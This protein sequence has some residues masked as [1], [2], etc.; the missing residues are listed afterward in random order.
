MQAEKAE[1][2]F[3]TK[4]VTECLIFPQIEL[5]PYPYQRLMAFEIKDAL[6]RL[7]EGVSVE[8]FE[9]QSCGCQF[10]RHYRIPCAHMFHYELVL[11]SSHRKICLD[12][13]F[14]NYGF[15]SDYSMD[16]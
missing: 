10:F 3:K 12:E 7:K 15:E 4:N 8:S 1:I 14:D 11:N 6:K 16:S 9:E 5:F 2:E 13:K